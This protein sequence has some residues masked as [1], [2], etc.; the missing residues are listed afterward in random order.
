[1]KTTIQVEGMTCEHCERSV[2]TA[3]MDVEGVSQVDVSLDTGEVTITH[4]SQADQK[5][6]NQAVEDQGYDVKS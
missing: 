1:M 2:K 3:L 4:D 5:E 6:F